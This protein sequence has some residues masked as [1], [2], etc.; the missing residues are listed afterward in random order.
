MF[1][2]DERKRG[3]P[4]YNITEDQLKVF[5]GKSDQCSQNIFAY[6]FPHLGRGSKQTAEQRTFDCR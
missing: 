5:Q 6:G 3:C 1:I 4:K 2:N